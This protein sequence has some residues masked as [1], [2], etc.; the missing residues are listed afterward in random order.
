M[1][2]LNSP[3]STKTKFTFKNLPTKKTL[4]PYGFAGAFY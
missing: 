4:R 1:D 3:I 2:N